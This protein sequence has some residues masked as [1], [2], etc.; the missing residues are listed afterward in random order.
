MIV[1]CFQNVSSHVILIIVQGMRSISVT[2]ILNTLFLSLSTHTSSGRRIQDKGEYK[3]Q[4]HLVVSG[5]R[6]VGAI[7]N[8]RANTFRLFDFEEDEEEDDDESDEEEE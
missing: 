1:W 5:S 3:S 2:Y 6:A 7:T 8:E 4:S